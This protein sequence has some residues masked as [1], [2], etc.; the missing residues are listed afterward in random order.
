M[1]KRRVALSVEAKQATDSEMLR[2]LLMVFMSTSTVSAIAN[3]IYCDEV[4]RQ[5]TN[6]S[7]EC[8]LRTYDAADAVDCMDRLAAHFGHRNLEFAFMGDSRMRQQFHSFVMVTMRRSISNRF[9][10]GLRSYFQIMTWCGMES[11]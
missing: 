5:Q 10:L 2:Y 1:R 6:V 7:S 9:N 3:S 4:I 8:K 11:L